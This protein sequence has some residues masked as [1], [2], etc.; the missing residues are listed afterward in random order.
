L[1]S[2][3]NELILRK[4]QIEKSFFDKEVMGYDE[5]TRKDTPW[6]FEAS[7]SFGQYK[8]YMNW[9]DQVQDKVTKQFYKGR[10]STSEYDNDG[11]EIPGKTTSIDLEPNFVRTQIIRLRTKD[12]GEFLYSRGIITGYNNFQNPITTSFQEPEIWNEQQFNHKTE[13]IQRLNTVKDIC[14][15]PAGVIPHYTMDFNSDNVDELMKNV[16]PKIK[17]IV[18]EEGG[19]VKEAPDLETFKTKSFDYILK[20][21]YL[22]EKEKAAK[23]EEFQTMQAGTKKK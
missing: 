14:L 2:T 13:F 4:W 1:F 18:R 11:K 22:T 8:E 17:L 12:K 16:V 21:E 5:K 23:L 6:P 10:K 9:L 3:L 20:M 7:P 19:R 15:G